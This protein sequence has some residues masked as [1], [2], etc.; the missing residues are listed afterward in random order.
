MSSAGDGRPI[1]AVTSLLSLI[2]TELVK[3]EEL[4]LQASVRNILNWEK[5]SE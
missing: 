4:Q 1:R 5:L 3:N 2:I